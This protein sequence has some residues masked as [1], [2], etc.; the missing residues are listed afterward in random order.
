[1]RS[2]ILLGVGL[3]IG[4]LSGPSSCRAEDYN[5]LT[6][7]VSSPVQRTD[8]EFTDSERDRVIPIRYIPLRE[9]VKS[10]PVVLFSHG[11]G[12]FSIPG[13]SSSVS[14]GPSEGMWLS[15]YSIQAVMREFGRISDSDK[16]WRRCGRR[17][18]EPI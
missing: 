16:G 10:A 12:G 7:I 15:S 1:M 2:H 4:L 8:T 18:A 17:P 9:G 3:L 11:L 14:I 13:A 5:P 6:A